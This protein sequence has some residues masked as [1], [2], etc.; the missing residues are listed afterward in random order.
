SELGLAGA[1]S[2]CANGIA[3]SV[4]NDV[5]IIGGTSASAP[6]FAGIV[7][8]L[9]QYLA[10]PFSPGLGNINAKLYSLAA[11]PSNGAFNPVNTDNNIAYCTPGT[12]SAQPVALRCPAAGFFGYQ[13]STADATTGYNLVAGL[14]SVNASALATAWAAS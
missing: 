8:L 7:T 4:D 1:G 2:S 12:P 3:N 14:G 10:G 9:N 6:V 11:T 13:A 5:S